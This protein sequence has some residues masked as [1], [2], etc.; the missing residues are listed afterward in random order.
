MLEKELI[1][2]CAPT[3]AGM[4]TANLFSFKFQEKDKF[5]KDIFALNNAANE[6]GVKID[7]LSIRENRALIYVYRI[8]AL[9]KDLSK[10]GVFDI[11][12]K[13]GYDANGDVEELLN[14]LKTRL[15]MT[16]CFPHEIGLFLGYPVEDV[17]EFIR[18]KG[19]NCKYCGLWKVYCNVDDAKAL[20][21][22]Y[23]HCQAV[24]RR[25]FNNDRNIAQMIVSA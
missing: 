11:L 6:K 25:V 1:Y 5:L 22:K 9:V 7:I 16:I 18:Q 17:S 12:T 14:V 4:K 8:K 10:P 2:Y 24:Y 13:Y 3:L 19:K 23:E 15:K 20:C 21:R